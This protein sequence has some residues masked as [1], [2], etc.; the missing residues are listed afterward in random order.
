MATVL[1]SMWCLSTFTFAKAMNEIEKKNPE[2]R[3]SLA[4]LGP[5]ERWT[6]HK[7]DP[8]W[9]Y[10]INKKTFVESFNATLGTDRCKPV[11]SLLE[12]IRRVTKVRL[13]ERR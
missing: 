11:L 9:K 8:E 6:K 3:K 4:N 7:F 13:A 2:A 1:S 10:D 12:G 5:Q